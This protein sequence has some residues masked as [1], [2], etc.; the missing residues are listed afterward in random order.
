MEKQFLCPELGVRELADA[1][2]PE[3]RVRDLSD[4]VNYTVP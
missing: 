1:V 2:Y 3:L 4:A